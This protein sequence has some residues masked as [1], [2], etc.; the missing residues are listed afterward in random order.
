M[1]SQRGDYYRYQCNSKHLKANSKQLT[2]YNATFVMDTNSYTSSRKIPLFI[3]ALI[4][5]LGYNRV[6]NNKKRENGTGRELLV[7]C[8]SCG[9]NHPSSSFLSCK[10]LVQETRGKGQG[11]VLWSRLK[12]QR[13]RIT[14]KDQTFSSPFC[15]PPPLSSANISRIIPRLG[16]MVVKTLAPDMMVSLTLLFDWGPC[17]RV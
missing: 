16:F 17:C 8:S 1:M 11:T 14:I 13:W 6:G 10:D 4:H 5:S 9:F 3:V 2:Q 7:K 12:D 15:A